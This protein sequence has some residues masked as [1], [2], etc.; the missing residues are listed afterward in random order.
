MKKKEL[1]EKLVEFSNQPATR[2]VKSQP[3]VRVE[4]NAKGRILNKLRN[5]K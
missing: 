2:P 4:L 3:E 1:K 5:N